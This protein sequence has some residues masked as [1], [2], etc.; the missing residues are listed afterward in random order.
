MDAMNIA[1][2]LSK[3]LG[4]IPSQIY[5]ALTRKIIELPID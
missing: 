3:A 5:E 1:V 4:S 2:N